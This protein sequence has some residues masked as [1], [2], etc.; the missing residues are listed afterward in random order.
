MTIDF[1]I[2]DVV[3]LIYENKLSCGTIYETSMAFDLTGNTFAMKGDV[4]YRIL[5]PGERN[6]TQTS[7]YANQLGRTKKELLNKL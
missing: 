7:R 1:F 2:G 3:Y 6:V 4:I 5:I